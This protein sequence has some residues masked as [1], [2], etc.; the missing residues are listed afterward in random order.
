MF[1]GVFVQMAEGKAISEILLERGE[2]LELAENVL[3]EWAKHLNI[4]P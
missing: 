2:Y 3:D 4:S 1:R